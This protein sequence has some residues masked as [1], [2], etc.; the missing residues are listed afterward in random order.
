MAF[1]PRYLRS[2]AFA[3]DYTVV[4][5]SHPREKTFRAR[6]ASKTP[7]PS[8]HAR[9]RRRMSR[10]RSQ[11]FLFATLGTGRMHV[12]LLRSSAPSGSWH[13]SSCQPKK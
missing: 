11:P 9:I 7:T 3:D 13:F 12:A 8:Q 1:G 6:R 5:P 4:E 2:L 10:Y